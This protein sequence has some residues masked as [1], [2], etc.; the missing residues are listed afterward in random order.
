MQWAMTGNLDEAVLLDACLHDLRYDG[1]CEKTRGTWLWRIIQALH[2][3]ARF[4]PAILEAMQHLTEV[5]TTQQLCQLAFHYASAGDE[6]FRSRLYQIVEVRPFDDIPWLL[7]WPILHLDGQQGFLFAARIRGQQLENR[8][9]EWD[10]QTLLDEAVERLGEGRVDELLGATTDGS[11][12]RYRDVWLQKKRESQEGTNPRQSHVT[13]MRAITVSQIMEAA[14]GKDA[15]YWLRGWGMHA[16]EADLR[17]VLERLWNTHDPS[18]IAKL[19]RV[20]SNRALPEFDPR[21]IDLCRHADPDVRKWAL[22]AM[23]CNAHPMVRTFAVAEL[24]KGVSSDHIIG[25][26]INNYEQGDEQRILDSMDIPEDACQLH[27]LLMDIIKI[28]EKNDTA[29]CSQLGVAVY[30]LT[31]CG[32]CRGSAARL[33]HNRKVAPSWLIEECRFDSEEDTRKLIEHE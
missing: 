19:L 25:L 16:D 8:E 11:L 7:E 3:E 10:D 9:W 18:V 33:L 22:I 5:W 31:P 26:F 24:Q 2:A 28:L 30:A 29:D 20:F 4:R 12:T 32:N 23:E 1:Q 6:A 27:Y 17:E 13:R 15:C 14:Q 21:L